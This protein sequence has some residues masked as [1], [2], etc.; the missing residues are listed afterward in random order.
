ML[1]RCFIRSFLLI[2]VLSVTKLW[3]RGH[4]VVRDPPNTNTMYYTWW[5]IVPS[6]Y[7]VCKWMYMYTLILFKRWIIQAMKNE[8]S[9]IMSEGNV[10]SKLVVLHNLWKGE[11]VWA[12]LK[13]L[14]LRKGTLSCRNWI[15]SVGFGICNLRN[16]LCSLIQPFVILSRILS[17][18][19]NISLPEL[20]MSSQSTAFKKGYIHN[21]MYS[22]I[23]S[24]ILWLYT[25]LIVCCVCS[26]VDVHYIGA[27]SQY[28]VH[29]PW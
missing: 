18:L 15:A 10:R 13:Y 26:W 1:F 29:R 22:Q 23:L 21:V 2:V 17:Q 27:L 28:L 16:I 12:H 5:I 24:T 3:M 14:D 7:Q 25:F 11:S 20:S 9:R 4:L 19:F 8:S 6:T